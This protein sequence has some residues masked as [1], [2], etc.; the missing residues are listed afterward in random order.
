MDTLTGILTENPVRIGFAVFATGVFYAHI[1]L[2]MRIAGKRSLSEMTTFD[3]ITNISIGSILPSAIVT[4]GIAFW[5]G[6]AVLTTL[7]GLQYAVTLAASRSRR[8]EELVTN[9][10]RLLYYDGDFIEDN[11]RAERVSRQQLRSKLRERGYTRMAGIDAIVLETS[12]S[13]SVLQSQGDGDLELAAD[14]T[15]G[16]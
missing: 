2:L 12:G 10:P 4:R 14:I 8:F 7:V 6:L 15:R 16:R 11:M 1:V 9:P 13:L 3:F 5:T